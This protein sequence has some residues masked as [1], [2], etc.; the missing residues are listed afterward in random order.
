MDQ[1]AAAR[2]FG[3]ADPLGRIIVWSSQPKRSGTIVAEVANLPE[4]YGVG[5]GHIHMAAPPHVYVPLALAPT[6]A[7]HIVAAFRGDPA[8]ALQLV[9]RIVGREDG[10]IGVEARTM[11]GWAG[12]RLARSR[13]LASVLAMLGAV[14]IV[15]CFLG[16]FAVAAYSAA[17]R[18][19]ELAIRVALG[20]PRTAVMRLV[21][22]PTLVAASIGTTAG[23]VMAFDSARLVS[24]LLLVN[25]ASTVVSGAIA[26]ATVGVIA[27]AAGLLP[28]L[29]AS[30]GDCS[31]LLRNV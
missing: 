14:A 18:E 29:R 1:A 6:R 24:G 10:S 17:V 25:A 31:A 4:I 22:R 19:R 26:A 27:L 7:L 20:S 23:L 5:M 16:V 30:K 11:A 9:G 13:L 12:A 15:V 28:A 21:L 2:L 8:S 3:A